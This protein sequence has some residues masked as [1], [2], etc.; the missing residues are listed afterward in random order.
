MSRPCPEC[1]GFTGELRPVNGANNVY[2]VPCDAY[3][4]CAPK[5]ET[6][7]TADP[8]VRKN[9]KPRQRVRILLRDNGRCVL[10]G[11]ADGQLHLGHLI[12][13]KD[14]PALGLSIADLNSDENLVTK[15]AECNLGLN[16]QS[17]TARLIA[18][19]IK[20][21]GSLSST[22]RPVGEGSTF[23]LDSQ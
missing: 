10:C 14:G 18:A 11:M 8:K 3:V 17:V 20:R 19:L 13:I 12:S 21:S 6:D 2:C 7:P 16:A 5:A 1:E 22:Q 23:T 15:C 4:Y 9:I